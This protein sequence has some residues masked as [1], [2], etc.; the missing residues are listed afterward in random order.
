MKKL[1]NT[2]RIADQSN[3][4]IVKPQK[5]D[6][7]LQ[8]NSAVYFQVGLILCLLVTYGL[9]EMKFEEQ[10]YKLAKVTYDNTKNVEVIPDNFTIEIEEVK[11]KKEVK[12]NPVVLT[13][14]PIIKKDDY[15]E[16]LPAEL[17]TTNPTV[18]VDPAKID[19]INVIK[20][21]K[22]EPE[23]YPTFGVEKVPV[24]PGCESEKSN[25]G[26]L[27]CM[28]DKLAKLVQKKFDK[29]L[30]SELGLSGIQRID[31]AFKIDKLGNVTEIQAR[32]PRHELEREAKRV[33]NQIP[34]MAP[35]KQ[36]EKP[37]VVQYNLPIVFKVQQ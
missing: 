16:K 11:E 23:F 20:E 22:D 7:N 18:S 4:S 34:Q 36:R 10:N 9:F 37:V 19:D 24:Y 5:H 30:A 28:S 12:K 35:G 31:V 32:A 26:R 8:K 25:K 14:D 13:K 1:K 15:I 29:D 3:A 33:A 17:L 27:K 2:S 6:A 21:P